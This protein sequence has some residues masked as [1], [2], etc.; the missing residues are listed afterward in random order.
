MLASLGGYGLGWNEERCSLVYSCVHYAVLFMA[1]IACG[2]GEAVS[3]QIGSS[4]G[5]LPDTTEVHLTGV[6]GL[7]SEALKSSTPVHSDSIVSVQSSSVQQTTVTVDGT[8]TLTG[9]AWTACGGI[10]PE[11]C[12][13]IAADTATCPGQ[14][15]G[16]MWS[17]CYQVREWRASIDRQACIADACGIPNTH[18]SECIEQWVELTEQCFAD[19]C[20]ETRPQACSYL[21]TAALAECS[22]STAPASGYPRATN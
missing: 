15:G 5:Q 13:G 12:L 8:E 10:I 17:A 2:P 20:D 22:H 6:D 21:R 1:L 9:T 19:H 18:D 14:T 11:A 7:S 16:C 4:Q 3:G